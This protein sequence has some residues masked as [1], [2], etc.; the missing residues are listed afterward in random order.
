MA[1]FMANPKHPIGALK[2]A[3]DAAV[4]QLGGIAGIERGETQTVGAHQAVVGAQPKVTIMSLRDGGDAVLRPPGTFL[5]PN[6]K[7]LCSSLLW[8]VGRWEIC[9]ARRGT[10]QR[11]PGQQD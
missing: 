1:R 7:K 2:Q 4:R 8:P 5:L 11:W 9:F 6:L 10:T 3:R